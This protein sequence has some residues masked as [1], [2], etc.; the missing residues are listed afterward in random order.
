M[1][2]Q[3]KCPGC[4]TWEIVGHLNWSALSCPTCKTFYDLAPWLLASK[5]VA[6]DLNEVSNGL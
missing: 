2:K 1:Q 6:Q 5:I 3:I 4:G